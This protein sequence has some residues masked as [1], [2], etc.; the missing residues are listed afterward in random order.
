MPLFRLLPGR[1]R[2]TF[3]STTFFLG[4]IFFGFGAPRASVRAEVVKLTRRIDEKL[5]AA[6]KSMAVLAAGR[7]RVGITEDKEKTR[8]RGRVVV[9][10]RREGQLKDSPSQQKTAFVMN[11][12]AA[13]CR[14]VRNKF[15]WVPWVGF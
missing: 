9:K 13:A 10:E 12:W 3:S 6:E 1:P 8:C 2:S 11:D 15:G 7:K 5:S 14:F 4:G